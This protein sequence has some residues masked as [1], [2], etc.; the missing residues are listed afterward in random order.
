LFTALLWLELTSLAAVLLLCFTV[1]GQPRWARGAAGWSDRF[2][3]QQQQLG[4]L[5]ALLAFL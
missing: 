1:L 4:F 3:G 5:Q 2:F